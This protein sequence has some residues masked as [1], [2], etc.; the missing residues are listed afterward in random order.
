MFSKEWLVN[1]MISN[2]IIKLIIASI[3]TT[4]KTDI[5]VNMSDENP[6]DT[7]AN[8]VVIIKNVINKSGCERN[9]FIL[10]IVDKIELLKYNNSIINNEY[11]V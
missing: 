7:Q 4:L 9:P 2:K 8:I 1:N 11:F 10:L 5:L 6:P 3:N